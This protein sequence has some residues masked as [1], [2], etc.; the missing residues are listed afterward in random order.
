MVKTNDEIRKLRK[1]ANIIERGIESA[2]QSITEG[3]SE[4]EVAKELR[5][6]A[7]KVGG[8]EQLAINAFADA[9]EIIPRTLAE[10]A[11][12]DAIDALVDLRAKHSKN[13]NFGVDVFNRKSADMWELGI[14]EPL[15][16]KIQ[17]IKSA[18]EASVMILRIDDIIAASKLEREEEK[19]KEEKKEEE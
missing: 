12:I 7:E 8:R 3:I 19:K 1:S 6:Y 13:K 9:L 4:I 16:I 11:G 18:S 5:E 10:S 2:L 14:I 15:K 17:A